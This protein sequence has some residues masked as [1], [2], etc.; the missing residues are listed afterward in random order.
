M[1]R[2]ARGHIEGGVYHV[3]ARFTD[4][5]FE[6]DDELRAR[7]FELL[8]IVFANS[9]WCLLTFALMTT[10]LH[11]LLRAGKGASEEWTRPLHTAIAAAIQERRRANGGKAFGQVFGG[12]PSEWLVAPE[13]VRWAGRY[14]HRNPIDGGVVARARDSRWTGHRMLIGADPPLACIDVSRSLTAFGFEPTPAGM[15]AFDDFVAAPD[16]DVPY[17]LPN[18]TRARAELRRAVGPWAE[19]GAPALDAQG[20][21]S[22]EIVTRTRPDATLLLPADLSARAI[23]EIVALHEGVPLDAVVSR[24]RAPAV[25][26]VRRVSLLTARLA[27]RPI[28]PVAAAL[29]LSRSAASQLLGDGVTPAMVLLVRRLFGG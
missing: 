4:H 29:N 26:R 11:Y 21:M 16:D 9:S 27:G 24:S 28:A 14:H 23:V 3:C 5:R 17:V 1:P 12:R 20:G 13:R 10:H 8:P 7:I 6:L 25:V 22:C 18:L 2:F 15:R 19:L